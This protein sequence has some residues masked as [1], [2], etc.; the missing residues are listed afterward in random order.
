MEKYPSDLRA[1]LMDDETSIRA[2]L[3]LP[4]GG[5][6]ATLG[7]PGLAFDFAG[8]AYV[9]PFRMTATLSAPALAN[10]KILIVLVE[11]HEVPADAF[12][13]LKEECSKLRI[14]LFHLPISDYDA[15]DGTFQN[16][17]ATVEPDLRAVFA[18]GG[19]VALSCHYG[20][21]RSG[22]IAASLLIRQG[23]TTE[24]AIA[25]IRAQFAESIESDKQLQ[26]LKDLS[27]AA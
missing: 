14:R 6:I 18:A 22:T 13:L 23:L 26:W 20:A 17:W 7:F 1:Q 9:D 15:P 21:G 12:Q 19:T 11:S 16:A 5:F 27:P 25:A 2:Y 10:C 8:A 3:P 4:E 24:A